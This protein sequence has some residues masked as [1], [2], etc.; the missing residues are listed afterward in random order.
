MVPSSDNW[1]Q[2]GSWSRSA[3][4]NRRGRCSVRSRFGALLIRRRRLRRRSGDHPVRRYAVRSSRSWRASTQAV[5]DSDP[6]RCCPRCP[7][8]VGPPVDSSP[9]ER[10]GSTER[11]ARQTT[12][13]PAPRWERPRAAS[14]VEV[15]VRGGWTTRRTQQRRPSWSSRS[16]TNRHPAARRTTSCRSRR[17]AD[18]YRRWSDAACR[19]R[20]H[21]RV[22]GC[23]HRSDRLRS[24]RRSKAWWAGRQQARRWARPGPRAARSA[25]GS[26][27]H[28]ARQLLGRA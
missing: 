12:K 23:D 10:P 26:P 22:N 25:R 2:V 14:D 3:S 15:S 17:G 20:S 8:L 13:A 4:R 16:P 6:P 9:Y 19:L 5:K 11:L 28:R 27:G 1:P 24:D 21:R 7:P 18:G